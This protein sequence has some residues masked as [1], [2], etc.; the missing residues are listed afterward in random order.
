VTTLE[1]YRLLER[2]VIERRAKVVAFLPSYAAPM[3]EAMCTP[4]TNA[5]AL[6]KA[7][8]VT[9]AEELTMWEQT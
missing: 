9:L 3:V 6:M 2:T 8:C 1:K 5:N 4:G 7:I